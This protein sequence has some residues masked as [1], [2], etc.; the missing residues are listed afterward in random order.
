MRHHSLR[1]NYNNLKDEIEK[2]Y[3]HYLDMFYK[4]LILYMVY[5]DRPDFPLVGSLVLENKL[6]DDLLRRTAISGCGGKTIPELR[7]LSLN[8]HAVLDMQIY[9]EDFIRMKHNQKAINI[10]SLTIDEN[11]NVL[12]T[13]KTFTRY[14]L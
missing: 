10:Y 3:F 4:A 7:E 12:V 8:L 1:I 13:N 2:D 5:N 11:Y 6:Y 14:A 9:L